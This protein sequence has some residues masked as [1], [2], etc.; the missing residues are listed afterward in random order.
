MNE[1][2]KIVEEVDKF[3]LAYIESVPHLEALLLLWRS[4][5]QVSTVEELAKALYLSPRQAEV[6]GH[7]LAR[8]GLVRSS[9]AGLAYVSEDAARDGLVGALHDTY[10]LETVRLSTLIHTRGSRA[11]RDF[12]QSFRLKRDKQ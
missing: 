1:H 11:V 2:E 6:I 8:E 7:D 12:A 5:P 4:R 9:E 10:A 3:V